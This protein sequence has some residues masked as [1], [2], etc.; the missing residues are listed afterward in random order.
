VGITVK[1]EKKKKKDFSAMSQR[2]T[3]CSEDQKE[4]YYQEDIE[5]DGRII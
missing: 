2:A 1:K 4:K 3:V 5:K